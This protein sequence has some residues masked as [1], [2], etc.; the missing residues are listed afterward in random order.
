MI[1]VCACRKES[2]STHRLLSAIKQL[3]HV[4]FR[5]LVD[6]V[7][8]QELAQVADLDVELQREL[9]NL[10]KAADEFYKKIHNTAYNNM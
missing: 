1:D 3:T 4:H 6:F 8:R 9:F 10:S 5:E 7:L 2:K